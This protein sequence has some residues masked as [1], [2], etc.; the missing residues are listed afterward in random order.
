M[1]NEFSHPKDDLYLYGRFCDY[2]HTSKGLTEAEKKRDAHKRLRAY[3]GMPTSKLKPLIK[4][5]RVAVIGK[6]FNG[7][8]YPLP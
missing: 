7:G 1:Q 3:Y 5:R 6:S 4:K 2:F 8:S